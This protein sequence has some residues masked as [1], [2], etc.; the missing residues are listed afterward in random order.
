MKMKLL[1]AALLFMSSGLLKAQKMKILFVVSSHATKGSTGEKTGYFLGEVSHPWKVLTDAGYEIDFVSPKGGNPP[2]DGF[3]LNDPVNKEFWEN[4]QYQQKISHTMTPSEVNPKQYVAIY[5]AGGHG[6]MWDL[7]ENK[8]LAAIAAKIYE[9][10][11]IVAAD[12]HGPAGL[13]N[14]K[15][16]DGKYLI[17]GKKVNGFSN[18]EEEIVKLTKVVPFLL[19]DEL[20]KRGGIYEKSGPWQQHVTVDQRLITGQNPQSAKEVGEAIKEALKK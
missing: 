2:V 4:P 8:E 13:M 3:D 7:P 11:G 16:S 9:A 17:A 1:L 10:K 6:A 5:Y 14:V 19:E 12:C 15:L 18:E 20:K